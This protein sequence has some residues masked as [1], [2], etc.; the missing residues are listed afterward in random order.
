MRGFALAAAI[1]FVFLDLNPTAAQVSLADAAR[2][3]QW[4][5]VLQ[6]TE[7]VKDI[8]I[9][10]ARGYT[11]VMW[12]AAWGNPALVLKL[13]QRGATPN[14]AAPNGDTALLLALNNRHYDVAKLIASALPRDA[15]APATG[16][17]DADMRAALAELRAVV[18]GLP[19]R[20]RTMR[21]DAAVRWFE[22]K[23]PESHA[24]MI[25]ED[26]A[27]AF[28]RAAQLLKRLPL[29]EVV[30]DVT[31]ELETKLAHCRALKIGMGG[32][33][34]VKVNTRKRSEVAS[35]WQV[36]YLLKIYERTG[37]VAPGLFPCWS[38]P[39]EA[40]IEPGRYWMWARDPSTG[41]TSERVL[42]KAAGQKEMV[43]DIGVP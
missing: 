24:E 4:A 6:L 23:L 31:D 42:I 36:F 40:S 17:H 3:G 10:D 19:E 1:S 35:N 30:E 26:Y 7:R 41:K 32:S 27:A 38:S 29:P 15:P 9:R 20:V 11:A 25:T 22:D 13:L 37:D 18:N 39:A 28:R 43:V 12:A 16:T 21:L 8:D 34:A 5:A 33:I 14:A 2:A